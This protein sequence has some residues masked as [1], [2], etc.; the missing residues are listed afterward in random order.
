[1]PRKENVIGL[2]WVSSVCLLPAVESVF[3]W[4]VYILVLCVSMGFQKYI[5]LS[6]LETASWADSPRGNSWGAMPFTPFYNS[7]LPIYHTCH[8]AIFS[9]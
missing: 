4:D 5:G 8:F 9:P 3:T 7:R 1:M 2:V 6:I